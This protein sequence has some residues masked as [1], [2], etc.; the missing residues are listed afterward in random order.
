MVTI[1][2]LEYIIAVDNYRHF[3]SAAEKCFVTQPTLSMQIKKLEEYLG[4]TIFDR[5]KQPI[6]PTD[7][8]AKIIDQARNIIAETHKIDEIIK[9]DKNDIS[10]DL[11][12]GII[13]TLSPYLLPLFI[14]SF[15]KEYPEVNITIEELYTYEIEKKLKKDELDI[16]ILVTP[17]KDDEIE[18][19]ALFYEE[20]MIYSNKENSF[21]QD[22]E[23][24]LNDLNTPDLWLLNDGH[25]FRNQVIN[26]CKLQQG[27]QDNHK[28]KFD[29]GSLETIIKIVDREGGFTLIPELAGLDLIKSHSDQ[30]LCFSDYTPLR[31]VAV[32][33]TRHYTKRKIIDLIAKKI[34]DS[35]PKRMRNKDRGT[36]VE[37]R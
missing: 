9:T 28:F 18:E 10:G 7:L 20:M 11:K 15:T 36:I 12:I 23:I 8:G 31:E 21:K 2:Q 14:G 13:P 33:Y 16:G 27:R 6:M 4:V 29:G 26:L 37:W 30:V 1:T 3:A 19:R 25:C 32:V 22:D 17:L 5:T 34:T 24:H 35:I